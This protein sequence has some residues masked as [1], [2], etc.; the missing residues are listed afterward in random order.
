[1]FWC[2]GKKNNVKINDHIEVMGDMA[3]EKLE[4]GIDKI[5]DNVEVEINEQIE[6]TIDVIEDQTEEIIQ[7]SCLNK[8]DAN[9]VDEA[10]DIILNKT[11]D[12]LQEFNENILQEVEETINNKVDDLRLNTENEL[13]IDYP[14]DT[15]SKEKIRPGTPMPKFEEFDANKTKVTEWNLKYSPRPKNSL[16]KLN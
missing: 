13:I 15:N 9:K 16:R 10:V 3:Q 4:D 8:N 5:I 2:W 12:K 7:S 1:M 11:E 14:L 6:Q